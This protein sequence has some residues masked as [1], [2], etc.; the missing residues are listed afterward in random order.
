MNRSSDK[1][2][3]RASSRRFISLFITV[4][5]LATALQPCVMASVVDSGSSDVNTHHSMSMPSDPA[6]T[7]SLDCPHCKTATGGSD[8]CDSQLDEIC[9]EDESLV[10]DSR[11]KPVDN[12]KFDYQT[13]PLA[14]LSSHDY[15]FNSYSSRLS[16]ISKSLTLP[17]GP[18]LRDL[19]RVYLN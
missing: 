13:L 3:D 9:D 14:I 16:V 15:E 1:F 19:Y 5:W 17:A 6:D 8:H 12:E 10:Y 11:V 18:P 7:E 4:I 2:W